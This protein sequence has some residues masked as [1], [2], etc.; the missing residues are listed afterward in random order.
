MKAI[1]LLALAAVAGTA[2]AQ[3]SFNVPSGAQS[4]TWQSFNLGTASAAA[5]SYLVI[6][7][8]VGGGAGLS[9]TQ[10]SSEARSSL[11]STG[12]TGSSITPTYGAG[13][14]VYRSNTGTVATGAQDNDGDRTIWW[15]GPLTNNVAAGGNVFFN[16]RQ[17]FSG[18]NA[19]W[20]NTTVVLNPVNSTTSS[21]AGPAAP[22]SFV[23][24]GNVNP[25]TGTIGSNSLQQTA[26][27]NVTSSSSQVNWFRFNLTSAIGAGSGLDLFTSQGA[28]AAALDTR[29][30]VWRSTSSGLLPI[31]TSA[32]GVGNDDDDASGNFSALSFGGAGA[33]DGGRPYGQI[34]G[35]SPGLLPFDNR[36][37]ATLAAGE[38]FV[39]VGHFLADRNSTNSSTVTRNL[40]SLGNTIGITANTV[41]TFGLATTTTFGQYDLTIGVV[42]T[43]GA[44]ALAGLGGLLAAR[45][46]RA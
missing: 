20:T 26:A 15:T 7:D 45:R 4:T 33:T 5:S 19:N 13:N 41:T 30:I 25:I 21:F 36:D 10:W 14:V 29:I 31:D 2:V 16:R 9:T 46:R 11:S 27:N 39:S 1:G 37:G 17:T 22:T 34:T 28:A 35:V 23:D 32:L 43:P 8:W 40:D 42:P 38:Y 44:L 12:A 6:T 18:T 3:Q 24:F